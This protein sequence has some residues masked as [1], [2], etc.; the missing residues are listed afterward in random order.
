MTESYLLYGLEFGFDK[1]T[2]RDNAPRDYSLTWMKN[3][4]DRV[5]QAQEN[6]YTITGVLTARSEH[7]LDKPHISS[8]TPYSA[9]VLTGTPS[10]IKAS[11]SW[12]C[13]DFT[14]SGAGDVGTVELALHGPPAEYH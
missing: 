14:E 4:A 11:S 8:M 7:Q 2:E 1:P 5:Y 13:R 3:F 9:M 12:R 10:P 6:R